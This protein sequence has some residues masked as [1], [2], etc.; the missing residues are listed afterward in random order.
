[1][2][3]GNRVTQSGSRVVVLRFR[4]QGAD[5]ERDIIAGLEANMAGRPEIIQARLFAH[6][7]GKAIDYLAMVEARAPLG[8]RL[9]LAAFKGRADALDLVNVYAPY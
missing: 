5:A 6:D 7:T 9:D 3:P 4:N 2:W 1:M 8:E